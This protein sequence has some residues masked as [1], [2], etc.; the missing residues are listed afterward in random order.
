MARKRKNDKWLLVDSAPFFIH[1]LLLVSGRVWFRTAS[2]LCAWDHCISLIY[3][4][5]KMSSLVGDNKLEAKYKMK[6]IEEK[7]VKIKLVEKATIHFKWT[8]CNLVGRLYL[9]ETFTFGSVY[10]RLHFLQLESWLRFIYLIYKF[11]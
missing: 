5:D 11:F 8:I 9:F 3:I 6:R 4:Y 7:K 10:S 2:H 1:S